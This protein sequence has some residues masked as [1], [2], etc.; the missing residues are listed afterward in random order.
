MVIFKTT[1]HSSDDL[2][3]NSFIFFERWLYSLKAGRSTF[4]F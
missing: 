3:Y 2:P 1:A 4:L